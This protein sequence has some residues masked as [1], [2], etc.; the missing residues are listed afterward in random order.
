M[1]VATAFYSSLTGTA[2]GDALRAEVDSRLSQTESIAS[3]QDAAVKL[4]A[5][6]D[7]SDLEWKSGKCRKA[8]RHRSRRGFQCAS[9][10]AE[11]VISDKSSISLDFICSIAAQWMPDLGEDG[12][13]RAVIACAGGQEV[14]AIMHFIIPKV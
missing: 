4:N 8:S 3:W 2:I 13:R 5:F 14:P 1:L 9:R 10:S 6:C 11:G 7:L 12:S